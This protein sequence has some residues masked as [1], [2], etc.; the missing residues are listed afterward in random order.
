M[1]T[2]FLVL[3]TS[4]CVAP[5]QAQSVSPEVLT[6]AGN[7]CLTA[8][9]ELVGRP[10]HSL[11]LTQQTSDASGISVDVKVPQAT[12]PWACLTD[13]AGK[14]KETYFKGSEGAW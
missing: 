1:S 10:R 13:R 3:A 7:N 6:Q 4:A 14:V 11:K 5:V 9:A 12:G 8:V 2:L